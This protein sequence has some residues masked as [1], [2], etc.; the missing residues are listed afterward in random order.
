MRLLKTVHFLNSAN[1]PYA[2]VNLN[3]NIHV[4]GK[5]GSG[6][7]SILRAILFFYNPDTQ[8]L[9][10]GSNQKSFIDF[11]FPE[12]NSYVVYE[13]EK[14][15]YSYLV[16]AFKKQ[17][18]VFFRVVEAEFKRENF[19]RENR[20][21]TI[22]E[23][24]ESFHGE[25]KSVFSKNIDT[26]KKFKALVYGAEKEFS[27]YSLFESKGINYQSIPRTIGNIFLNYKL[28]SQFIKHSIINSIMEEAPAINLVSLK[29]QLGKFD[30]HYR[31]IKTFNTH[32]RSAKNIIEILGKLSE[33]ETRKKETAG[34][35]GF[36]LNQARLEKS[37][38]HNEIQELSSQIKALSEESDKLEQEFRKKEAELDYQA[39]SL[40]EKLKAAE[41]KRLHY[42]KINID[43]IIT[44]VESQATIEKEQKLTAKELALLLNDHMD[45]QQ[46][47][48]MMKRELIQ[49]VKEKDNDFNQLKNSLEHK[50]ILAKEEIKSGQDIK[51]QEVR[52]R[53]Q[54]VFEELKSRKKVHADK[55]A[56]LTEEQVR[57]KYSSPNKEKIDELAAKVENYQKDLRDK[58]FT[59][60]ELENKLEHSKKDLKFKQEEKNSRLHSLEEKQQSDL[61][62]LTGKLTDLEEKLKRAENSLTGFLE[63]NYPGY[64]ETI[65][66]VVSEEI[67]FSTGLEPSVEEK[68]NL[69]FGVRLNLSQ[70]PP[71]K[72]LE[73][74]RLEKE[75]LQM[76][77][78]RQTQ[79][80]QEDLEQLKGKYAE[81]ETGINKKI[82]D[83]EKSLARLKKE[84]DDLNIVLEHTIVQLN[85]TK[86]ES[87]IIRAKE[88]EITG[89]DIITQKTAMA[90]LEHEEKTRQ[91]ESDKEINLLK[92]EINLK[93]AG[94]EHNFRDQLSKAEIELNTF[95]E[96]KRENFTTIENNYQLD[97]KASGA[98]EH[99]IRELEDKQSALTAELDFIRLSLPEYYN[100]QTD[101]KDFLDK[102]AD[103]KDE[104]ARLSREKDWHRKEFNREKQVI[105]QNR[106]EKENTLKAK[107]V[108][109]RH[110]EIELEDF[111]EFKSSTLYTELA[112]FITGE[113]YF[114]NTD[115]RINKLTASLR[116]LKNQLLEKRGILR[117]K[118]T[119]YADNFAEDNIF[120]FRKDNYTEEDFLNFARN[121]KSF[122]EEEKLKESQ[123]LLSGSYSLIISDLSRQINELKSKGG[124]IQR[125]I[126]KINGSFE[127]TRLI[128]VIK[129]IE[130]RM[131]A[132]NNRII[133][134]L[135]K[136]REFTEQNPYAGEFNL[137]NQSPG[138]DEEEKA[139]SL[140]KNLKQSIEESKSD[141]VS[142]EE[143]F[144]I[145]FRIKENNNDTGFIE[146]LSN[147]G[148]N[149]TDVLIKA[150]IYLTLL[151]VAKNRLRNN[152]FKIHCI[153]DEVGIL[154]NNYLKY[155]IQF[156]NEKGILLINGSPNPAEAFL[157][158]YIYRV[159]K[160]SQSNSIVKALIEARI[161]EVTPEHSPEPSSVN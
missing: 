83:G 37:G 121:L 112:S 107:S 3:G 125:T 153:V 140:L 46:K 10:I 81:E 111:E 22:Q 16:I 1:M 48:E 61:K 148:S 40:Q 115:L 149:G 157:Y 58:A 160:D 139:I 45:L 52:Q 122:I 147:I 100:Y 76:Q 34:M 53:Y 158:D 30:K 21:M 41:D 70:L 145:E 105:S 67:L 43:K 38:L 99:R 64:R 126:T 75:E 134:F 96:L 142:L 79:E 94:L 132:G 88:L 84:T 97:L 93:I 146:R 2:R 56:D 110:L 128:D 141:K 51:I 119:R 77:L 127:K 102:V 131:K 108:T 69:L 114:I 118:I 87:D 23:I 74:Y 151:D 129:D 12:I 33:M 72:T 25:R 59:K 4:T 65:A 78:S 109:Y 106:E 103:F 60:K 24:L 150:M 92:D 123:Q 144:E 29:H 116:E 7:T 154:D 80:Y 20:V 68:N 55:L 71:A 143:S 49:A 155:L 54:G 32:F 73:A 17:N 124:E 159:R 47:Y 28:D 26:Y 19:I 101:K 91:E 86:S 113:N 104:I 156:A 137:F 36:R 90:A 9:G 66:R 63:K 14:E 44:A 18:R 42:Q 8:S 11:Y 50:F 133:H 15:T 62:L 82:T 5:N 120:S 6:K 57:I 98:N 13:I 135:E 138:K 35:L 31:D 27:R 95:K 130:L 161:N 117:E 89:A 39:R 136:I 85:R 152:D